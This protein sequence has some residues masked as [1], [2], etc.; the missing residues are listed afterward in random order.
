MTGA[1]AFAVAGALVFAF[2]PQPIAVDLAAVTN[3]PMRVTVDEEGRTRVKEVYVVSAPIAGRVLRIDAHVG[4]LV[5]AGDTVLATI[6]PSEPEF[7]DVRSLAQAEAAVRAAD[8][9]RDIAVANVARAEA[10]LEF[11][12]AEW[13]RAQALAERGNIS[14]SSLDRAALE[15]KTRQADL[16][17]SRAALDVR[18]FE[19]ETANARLIAPR[20]TDIGPDAVSCCV[21]VSAPVSGRILKVMHESESVVAAGTPLLEVGDPSDLEIVVELLSTDAVRVAEGADV[22][23]EAW[24]GDAQL[25]GRVRRIE[26]YGFTK[27]SALGIEEQ[28]VN[29]IIEFTGQPEAWRRLGHGFRVE[30]RVVVWQ[31]DDIVTVPLGALFRNGDAWAVFVAEIGRARIRAVSIGQRNGRVAQILDGLE[32]GERVVLHPS[33]RVHN[34]ARVIARQPA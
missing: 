16:A 33:D 9:G 1:G 23:I 20:Q 34:D 3:G 2:W 26:P 15:V 14:R 24:G 7:L 28:R 17:T 32:V 12:E 27:V 25:P 21:P 11:A 6:M 8:A 18:L 5:A 22:M 29:V 19:L 13:S 10:E 30:V 4:D 31:A